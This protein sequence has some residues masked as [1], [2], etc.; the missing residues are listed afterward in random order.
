MEHML[1]HLYLKKESIE[2]LQQ[3]WRKEPKFAHLMLTKIFSKE[4]Y[5]EKE[6]EIKKLFYKRQ[7]RPDAFSYAIAKA[8]SMHIFDQKE[9]HNFLSIILERPVQGILGDAFY[10]SWKD[11]TVLN[12]KTQEKTGIDI[13][14]DFTQEWQE[15]WGG[16]IVYKNEK[17]A[18]L[19]LLPTPNTLIIVERKNTQKYIQYINNLSKGK[20]RYLL[21]GTVK[22][23]A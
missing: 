7:S 8:A 12:R 16:S 11:Y 4:A 22:T 13:I 10:Y 2:T 20:K 9:L 21:I 1:N 3:N 23:K 17:G 6:K 14:F 5:K 19:K 18:Y 15:E